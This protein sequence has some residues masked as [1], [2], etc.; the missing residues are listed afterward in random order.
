ARGGPRIRATNAARTPIYA[1]AGAAQVAGASALR[2]PYNR[3]EW[4][5]HLPDCRWSGPA[6]GRV[7]DPRV[8]PGDVMKNLFDLSGKVAIVTGSS[9]GIGRAIAEHLAAH[10]ARVV[11]SSRK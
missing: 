8:N 10:G 4:P 6:R 7:G 3:P 2:F 9:R 11:V 5:A 1:A